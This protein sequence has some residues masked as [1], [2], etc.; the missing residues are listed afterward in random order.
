M[1]VLAPGGLVVFSTN[2]QRFR[3]DES[4]SQRY[5]IRDISGKTLPRDFERNPRIHKCF[6]IRVKGD[7]V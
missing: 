6:E 1:R 3:L 5:D 2:S 4:L 7:P